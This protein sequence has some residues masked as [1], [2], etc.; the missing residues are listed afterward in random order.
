MKPATPTAEDLRRVARHVKRRAWQRLGLVLT[1]AEL[2]ELAGRCRSRQPLG[3]TDVTARL[4][5][6][7][8]WRGRLVWIVYD[9]RLGA[10]ITILCGPPK[11]IV[12]PGRR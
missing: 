8:R 1:D 9:E 2:G 5:Y 4:V 12:R 7:L 3:R 11:A 10:V 6:R